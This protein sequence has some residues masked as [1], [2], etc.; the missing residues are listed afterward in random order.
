VT[1]SRQTTYFF[2]TLLLAVPLWGQQTPDQAAGGVA[3]IASQGYYLGGASQPLQALTGASVAFRIFQPGLGFINGNLE[4]YDETTRGRLGMNFVILNGLSWKK[5]RWTITAGDA[6]VLTAL[7][8]APFTNYVYPELG[9]RGA[10]V[11]MNDG[12][13]QYSFFA[14]EE[15][16]QEGPRI[17]FRIGT[18]QKIA[19]VSVNQNFG[20]N[21]HVGVRVL[22]LSN[23]ADAIPANPAY[24][25]IGSEFTRT[26]MI[27]AQASWTPVKRLMF[28]SDASAAHSVYA[29][30]AAYPH[31]EPFSSLIGAAWDT[32]SLTIRASYGSEGRSVLPALGYYLGDR[33]GSY[34]ETQY[35]P[36][37][38]LELFGSAQRSM[39][40]LEH[41]PGVPDLTAGQVAAGL[42]VTLLRDTS[43]SGQYSVIGLTSRQASDPAANQNQTSRQSQLSISKRVSR[44]NLMV[45]ARSLDLNASFIQQKQTSL[46]VRN[47]VQFSRF[48]LTGA[49]RGQQQNQSGQLENT[50]YVEGGGQVRL[51]KFSIYG[52]FEAGNDL[53]NK[54]LFA[55]NTASTEVLGVTIPLVHGWAVNAEAFRTKLISA[56]NPE[57]LF[58]LA[59]QG[60]DLS[61][62]LDNFNQWSFYLRFSR[63]EQWGAPILEHG[64]VADTN[65]VYGIIEGVVYDL[66]SGPVPAP[67]IS[68]KLD[69]QRATSTD[70]T[71]HYRFDDVTEGAHKVELNMDELPAEFSPG[72]A[73]PGPADVKPRKSTRFDLQI[74]RADSAIQGK[75]EGIAPEDA[76]AIFL[77]DVV[78]AIDPGTYTTCSNGGA[79]GFYNLTPGQYQISIDTKTLPENYVLDSEPVVSVDLTSAGSPQVLFRIKK[80]VEQLPVRR[81]F[82]GNS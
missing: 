42:N 17:T 62:I 54:S 21:V 50:V 2:L 71:G 41:N 58:V 18:P 38:R 29:A 37:R 36:F 31:Q 4:G 78:V 47:T 67:G 76:G 64:A 40:N 24:F 51:G 30:S 69:G 22:D 6:K 33:R 9:I 15:T 45:T 68:L 66:G 59:T 26:D 34:V 23:N 5:R 7:V 61:Q 81:V 14:G 74:V 65:A 39:N 20:R 63:R 56:L 52:Q 1:W 72:A 25:P 75:V 79:F 3:D 80:Q 12:I 73:S 49:V 77:N 43:I 8:P 19:G 10:K 16:L 11:D 35:R 32:K 46:E 44:N 55:T 53:V 48:L 57:S 13:R 82:A 27:T 60:D 28:F 70:A